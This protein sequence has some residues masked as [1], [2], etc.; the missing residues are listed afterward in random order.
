MLRERAHHQH[1]HLCRIVSISVISFWESWQIL[2]QSVFY[3]VVQCCC[4]RRII[5]NHQCLS[6]PGGRLTHLV[7]VVLPC[8]QIS[9]CSCTL[10]GQVGARKTQPVLT[11]MC[12][13]RVRAV[14]TFGTWCIS[15]AIIW[16]WLFVALCVTQNLEQHFSLI[17]L[18]R[19]DV[20]RLLFLFQ[21]DMVVIVQIILG[22][23]H[24]WRKRCSS[25]IYPV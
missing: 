9:L 18:P 19:S 14:F 20:S 6:N 25:N 10:N 24:H 21:E 7:C 12:E 22:S 5:Q 11:T 1:P 16:M 8:M 17:S 2:A 4:W 13:G 3:V 23:Q 15:E